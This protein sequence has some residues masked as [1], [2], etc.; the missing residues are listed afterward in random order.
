MFLLNKMD[1]TKTLPE[2]TEKFQR[3]AA[4]GYLIVQIRSNKS[5]FSVDG[6]NYATLAQ[7]YFDNALKGLSSLILPTEEGYFPAQE[8]PYFYK[9]FVEKGNEAD[10]TREIQGVIKKVR[11]I[12]EDLELLVKNPEDFYESGKVA[13]LS[14][15]L[16]KLWEAYL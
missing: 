7:I 12:K 4:I 14:L 10:K 8:T 13:E 11:T 15:G 2:Q 9:A 16:D 5:E 6:I 3:Q 1:Q